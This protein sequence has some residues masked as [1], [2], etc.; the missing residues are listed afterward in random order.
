MQEFINDIET[1]TC[2]LKKILKNPEAWTV[3][4]NWLLTELAY[5][6]N[7]IEGNTLT[8]RETALAITENITA[9]SKPIKDY[10]EARNHSDAFKLILKLSKN[11]S[12]VSEDDILTIH[13]EILKGINDSYSGRYRN[14]NVRISGSRVVLPNSAKVYDLMKKFNKWLFENKFYPPHKASEAHLKL[15]SIHPFIDGNGRTAR[16]LM[17]LILL[18]AGYLPSIIRRRDRRQYLDVIELA[19]ITDNKISYAEFMTKAYIRSLDTY[20]DIFNKNKS[21]VQYNKLL[22][23][24]KFAEV[25]G[26]PVSTIRYYLRVGKI[27]PIAKTDSD[28]MLFSYKQ[29]KEVEKLQNK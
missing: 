22:K 14:I 12:P 19:Q 28:Y 15:I 18:K 5:T 6:S 4:K 27:K 17:N 10:I 23:I 1:R 24:S 21:D 9:S 3:L 11:K 8:R 26:M 2:K 25:A 16:L 29:I 13:R 20:L 7:A